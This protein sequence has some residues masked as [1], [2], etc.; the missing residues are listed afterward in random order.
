MTKRAHIRVGIAGWDYAD[1]KG[2][3]YPK[4]RPKGF[5]PLR[6][7]AGYLDLIEINS[8]FYRPPTKEVAQRWV[9]RVR[10]VDGFRFSAKLYRRFTHERK[11]AWTRAEV[12]EARAGLDALHGSGRLNAVL[13]QFPWS[14]RNDDAGRDWLADLHDTFGEYP[15]VV[16]VRHESWNEPSFL[17]WLAE[18]GIGFVNVDQPLFR[19]SI[20]P[21]SHVTA[22][23]GYVRVHGRN[24]SDWFRKDAGR[25]ARYDYLYDEKE[26]RPWVQRTRAVAKHPATAEVDVVFNNHYKGQA[27]VNA[28][29][30]R[31]LLERR[32]QDA[33]PPLVAQYPA[34]LRGYARA[35][36]QAD[37][38]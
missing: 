10:D 37:A 18:V 26:L 35:L 25:D 9:Q 11:T 4:P 30:F 12:K 34:E 8:T 6:Y 33:P 27:V 21:S 32:V 28:V 31:K 15:L 13:V 17:Q 14:F 23:V 24:Y 1:W 2:V 29:Q 36:P 22:A 20:K 19:R 7:L 5:D 38:A 3:V 16:E